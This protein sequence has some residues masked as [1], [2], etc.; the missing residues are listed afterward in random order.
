ML[1]PIVCFCGKKIKQE[2]QVPCGGTTRVQLTWQSSPPGPLLDDI[3]SSQC[4]FK[5]GPSD[6]KYKQLEQPSA[7]SCPAQC[8]DYFRV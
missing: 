6:L 5:E 1:L 8:L 3:G 4:V 7:L 2:K